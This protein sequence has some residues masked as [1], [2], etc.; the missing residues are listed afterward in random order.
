MM[1]VIGNNISNINTVGFKSGRATFSEMFVQTL[2]GATSSSNGNSGTNPIQVGLGMNVNTLDTSFSQGNIETTGQS[3]DLAV[4][5][6]GFF[7]VNR[8]GET[9]YTRMGTF[10]FDAEGRLVHPGTGAVLQ[11]K[12]ADAAGKIPQGST[13]EDIKIAFDRKSPAKATSHVKLSGNLNAAASIANITLNGTLDPA[14]ALGTHVDL[15]ATVTDSFGQSHDVALRFTNAGANTWDLTTESATGG[16]VT[17]GT[18]TV[19]FDPVTGQLTGFSSVVPITLTSTL[20]PAAPDM[21]IDL[22]PVNLREQA[23]SSVVNGVFNKASDPVNAS[24]TIFDSLGNRHTLTV[25]FTK[26]LNANEWSWAASVPVP[27]SITAGDS[28]TVTFN[29]DGTLATFTYT[30]GASTVDIDPGNGAAS[31]S[32]SLNAGIPGVFAGIT[33]NEGSSNVTP[34]DQD[35][36]GVG[37]L[38]NISI[39]LGGN[40]VGAFSNGTVLTLGRVML[41]EFN[42]PGS[43]ERV[44]DSMYEI[45]GNSGT[46]AIVSPGESSQSTIVSGALEQSNVDLADEFTKMIMAQRGFQSSARVITTSDE[47]LQEVVNLKR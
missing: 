47:F 39:D 44:G 41:V 14:A 40:I 12:V 45:S 13:L 11:G 17:G 35:G 19:T 38:S 2:R 20:T 30:G 15:T 18:A 5:G 22:R 34:R 26:T 10:Q 46:P 31:M 23:G 42:N 43:L 25:T 36:Y 6:S 27:A 24:V 32:I 3:T 33:Q 8:N 16:T 9:L 28:G 7:I 29:P 4:Q 37:S 1:D 21:T